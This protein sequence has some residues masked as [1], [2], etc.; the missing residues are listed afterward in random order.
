MSSTSSTIRTFLSRRRRY[1]ERVDTEE[2]EPTRGN[3]NVELPTNSITTEENENENEDRD[4]T[5]TITSIPLAAAPVVVELGTNNDTHAA[6]HAADDDE[7]A[8]AASDEDRI[9]DDEADSSSQGGSRLDEEDHGTENTTTTIPSSPPQFESLEELIAAR[10]TVIEQS[11]PLVFM[12]SYGLAMLWSQALLSGNGGILLLTLLLTGLFVQYIEQT[13][14]H[15]AVYNLLALNWEDDT[16]STI[17]YGNGADGGVGEAAKIR[18][19][20]FQYNSRASLIRKENF[21]RHRRTSSSMNSNS[22][23]M[24]NGEEENNNLSVFTIDDE[25][26]YNYDYDLED[27]ED[28]NE[29]NNGTTTKQHPTTTAILRGDKEQK[30]QDRDDDEPPPVCSICLGDYAKGEALVALTPCR[31]VFHEEC[32]AAWTQHQTRCPLCNVD[33]SVVVMD[34]DDDNNIV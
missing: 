33:L 15:I 21:G 22:S 17:R 2:D 24:N 32:I 26:D 23:D 10:D 14:E 18:W 30:E 13:Q 25:D 29:N 11:R 6:D 27:D 19:E 20:K 31:H 3:R 12:C 9:S 28:D 7:E 8:A 5:A 34:D 1:F 4:T 16:P